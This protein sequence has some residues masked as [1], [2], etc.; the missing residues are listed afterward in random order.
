[1]VPIPHDDLE[2]IAALRRASYDGTSLSNITEIKEEVYSILDRVSNGRFRNPTNVV[3]VI[4]ADMSNSHEWKPTDTFKMRRLWFSAPGNE[5]TYDSERPEKKDQIVIFSPTHK[6]LVNLLRKYKAT[7]KWSERDANDAV[8]K[9]IAG[10][11]ISESDEDY[12]NGVVFPQRED[13]KYPNW[14]NLPGL[15]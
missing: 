15:T 11:R 9:F 7:T 6:K 2:R 14:A 13:G 4:N 8:P 5:Y 1:M 3:H 12:S 10:E